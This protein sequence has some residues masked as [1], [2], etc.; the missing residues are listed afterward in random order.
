MGFALMVMVY[1]L[2]VTGRVVA[3]VEPRATFRE[4]RRTFLPG[5]RRLL[6]PIML[7]VGLLTGVAT[8][9][10]LGAITVVYAVVARLH[11]PRADLARR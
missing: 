1:L 8:P 4:L 6:A 2:V 9:T 3:P 5:C 11:V 7:V 10:E